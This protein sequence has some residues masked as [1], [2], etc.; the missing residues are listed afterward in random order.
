MGCPTRVQ[1]F[2]VGLVGLLVF[3]H[4]LVLKGNQVANS[5]IWKPVTS[6]TTQGGVGKQRG[7]I[8]DCHGAHESNEALFQVRAIW[9]I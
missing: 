6:K 4:G 5:F 3:R 8:P 7:A 2:L 1:L 9:V